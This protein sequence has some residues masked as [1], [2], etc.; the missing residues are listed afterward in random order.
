MENLSNNQK[1]NTW[2]KYISNNKLHFGWLQ[3]QKIQ[4]FKK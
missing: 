1:K 2:T 4:Q 3:F